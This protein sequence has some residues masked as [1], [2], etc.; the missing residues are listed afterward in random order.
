M[1]NQQPHI[2]TPKESEFAEKH[3]AQVYSFLAE[4]NLTE[5]DYYDPAVNGFLKAV[6][7]YHISA[8]TADFNRFAAVMM[9]VECAAHEKSLHRA[10]TVISFSECYE[11]A[12]EI[13]EAITDIKNTMNEA[14]S[15]IAFDETMRSFNAT[16]KRIV[17]LLLKGYSKMDIVTMLRMSVNALFDEISLIQNKATEN[18][19]TMAA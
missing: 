13:E 19:L 10:P 4:N 1:L 15:A 9:S 14:I 2:F 5:D 6:Q 7:Q 12:Y 18:L 17:N 3:F 11:N 8:D 16:Q